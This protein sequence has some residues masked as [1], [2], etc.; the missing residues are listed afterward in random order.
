MKWNIKI[1]FV[2]LV[3]SSSCQNVNLG[4]QR[5]DLSKEN[6]KGKVKTV[7]S[8]LYKGIDKFGKLSKG[9]M[10]SKSIVS[11]NEKGIEIENVSF[12]MFED[13]DF[14]MN[15]KSTSVY[16]DKGYKIECNEYDLDNGNK[17][18]GKIV[19]IYDNN[20]NNIEVKSYDRDGKITGKS[21]FKYDSRGNKTEQQS[22][23]KDNYQY[24]KTMKYDNRDNIVEE[25]IYIISNNLK[26]KVVYKYDDNGNEIETETY[27]NGKFEW[28]SSTKYEGFDEKGNWTTSIWSMNTSD[29]NS[30]TIKEREIEYY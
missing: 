29:D 10:T 28:S 15:Y 8:Y 18:I 26:R 6:L 21:I 27:L 14:K 25:Q 19:Y 16:N 12:T 17:L 5:N 13:Q 9:K 7:K 1:L 30:V 4:Q 20:G 3:C 11:Y 24:Q 22:N 2:L 23:E